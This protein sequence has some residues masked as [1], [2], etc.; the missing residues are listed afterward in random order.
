MFRQGCCAGISI[1]HFS[2]GRIAIRPYNARRYEL[3]NK[4]QHDCPEAKF[5]IPFVDYR[6]SGTGFPVGLNAKEDE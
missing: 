3:R 1:R 6:N 4:Y 5:N 2:E